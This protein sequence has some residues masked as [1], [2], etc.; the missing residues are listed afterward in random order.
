MKT[1]IIPIPSD[2]AMVHLQNSFRAAS[3]NHVSFSLTFVWRLLPDGSA[4]IRFSHQ[5]WEKR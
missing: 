5:P 3:L 2:L 1:E 4:S